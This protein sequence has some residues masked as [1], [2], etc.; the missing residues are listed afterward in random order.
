MYRG[1]VFYL[2]GVE[3]M[4][5]QGTSKKDTQVDNDI[6]PDWRVA[7]KL[8]DGRVEIIATMDAKLVLPLAMETVGTRELVCDTTTTF[9]RLGQATRAKKSLWCWCRSV[10]GCGSTCA[11]DQDCANALAEDCGLFVLFDARS[12]VALERDPIC[13]NRF[14]IS[15]IGTARML[16]DGDAK[17]APERS[18][19]DT[20]LYALVFE[21][22]RLTAFGTFIPFRDGKKAGEPVP[23]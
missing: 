15:T 4:S 5:L 7:I 16:D 10:I 8:D 6:R 14:G 19:W 20:I 11:D 9:R 3:I 13:P 1:P 17:V 23:A 2:M 12:A 22:R 21:L 18:F